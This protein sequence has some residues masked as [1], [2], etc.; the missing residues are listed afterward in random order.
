MFM[1]GFRSFFRLTKS[2]EKGYCSPV[3][4]LALLLL[5]PAGVQAQT[6]VRFGAVVVLASQSPPPADIAAKPSDE[7]LSRLLP[8]LQ[9]VFR[10]EHYTV[11]TRFSAEAP[12]GTTT[13]WKAGD[14]QLELTAESLDG[15]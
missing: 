3:I 13:Q 14:S 8:K 6:F 12:V 7:R 10:Y 15:D 9:Q 2:G 4:A 5:V 11:L 1:N